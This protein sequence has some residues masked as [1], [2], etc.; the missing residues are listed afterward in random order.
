KKHCYIL[1]YSDD[2]VAFILNDLPRVQTAPIHI[3]WLDDISKQTRLIEEKK[4]VI[5]SYKKIEFP[6]YEVI[7]AKKWPEEIPWLGGGVLFISAPT[8]HVKQESTQRNR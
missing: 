4:V 7:F 5:L 8:Q 1:N 6:G 3:P 2:C